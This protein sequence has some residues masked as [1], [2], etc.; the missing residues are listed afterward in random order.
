MIGVTMVAANTYEAVVERGGIRSSHRVTLSLECYRTLCGGAF[1][2]EW[3]IVQVLRF[4]REREP[5]GAVADEFDVEDI[6]ARHADFDA[7]IARRLGIT[8]ASRSS[9]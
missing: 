2:H 7:D 4:L 8:P 3:V 9:A 6:R 1:T 5:H